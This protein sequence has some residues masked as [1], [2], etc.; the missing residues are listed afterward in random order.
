M[1]ELI[2]LWGLLALPGFALTERHIYKRFAHPG[3]AF[4]WGINLIWMSSGVALAYIVTL[5]WG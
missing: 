2:I 1:V 3:E 5:I 4:R